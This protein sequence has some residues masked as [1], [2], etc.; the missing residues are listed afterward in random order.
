MDV[1]DTIVLLTISKLK[2]DVNTCLENTIGVVDTKD[3]ETLDHM[4]VLPR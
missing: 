4:P 2:C 1:E 3:M